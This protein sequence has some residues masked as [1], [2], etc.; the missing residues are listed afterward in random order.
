MN[1]RSKRMINHLNVRSFTFFDVET[2]NSGNNS[3]C[4]IGIIR[5]EED[6]V[7]FKKEYLVNPEARFD[8][9]NIEI[10]GIT[11]RMVEQAPI[12]P[13]IWPE[14]KEFFTNG[15]VVAHNATFDLSV[16]SKTLLAYDIAIPEFNYICTLEKARKHISKNEFGGHK[17]NV[18]CTAFNIDLTNHHNA[19]CDTLA[20][21]EIFNIFADRF[22]L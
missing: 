11:P 9:T 20:C 17:L 4:A 2:P 15:I 16:I 14:I 1:R 5:M 19:M 7:I 18:L 8:N 12:F 21:K 22:G 13:E 3:I 10:H 6:A